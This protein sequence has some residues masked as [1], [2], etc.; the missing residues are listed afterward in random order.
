MKL[1]SIILSEIS[2]VFKEKFHMISLEVW[3]DQNKLIS[4]IEQVLWKQNKITGSS[5]EGEGYK[6]GNKGKGLIKGS[7]NDQ[8]IWTTGL[9]LTVGVG[10]VGAGEN[11]GGNWDMC[12]RTIIKKEKIV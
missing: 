9:G 5:G 8:W 6:G 7:T 11:N 4:E 3:N 10:V 1:D 12:N 2:Q